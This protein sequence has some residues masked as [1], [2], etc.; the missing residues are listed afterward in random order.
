MAPMKDCRNNAEVK[1]WKKV[2]DDATAPA[3]KK[4]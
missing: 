2:L 3:S 1:A 4:G